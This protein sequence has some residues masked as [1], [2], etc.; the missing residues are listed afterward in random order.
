VLVILK[1]NREIAIKRNYVTL[2]RKTTACCGL[3]DHDQDNITKTLE[4]RCNAVPI[5]VVIFLNQMCLTEI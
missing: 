2:Y 1:I 3:R 4:I 5:N